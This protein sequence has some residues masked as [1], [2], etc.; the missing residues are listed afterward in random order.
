[1]HPSQTRARHARAR[2]MG[3]RTLGPARSRGGDWATA[4]TR[5]GQDRSQHS[6]ETLPAHDTQEGLG[7]E[8]R[9]LPLTKDRPLPRPRL[10]SGSL[11][12]APPCFSPRPPGPAPPLSPVR[13]PSRQPAHAPP[14]P[15]HGQLHHQDKV[16]RRRQLHPVGEPQMV[17]Q[18]LHLLGLSVV[19][20]QAAG[21]NAEGHR[22]HLGALLGWNPGPG[23]VQ[24]H[25]AST[26]V[27][28][29]PSSSQTS[30]RLALEGHPGTPL[31]TSLRSVLSL[32]WALAHTRV[33]HHGSSLTGVEVPRQVPDHPPHPQMAWLFLASFLQRE[34]RTSRCPVVSTTYFQ[35]TLKSPLNS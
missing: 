18:N 35:E 8:R 29:P 14:D 19:L 16:L 3:L 31:Q 9:Q 28:G 22:G 25:L 11:T 32:T 10:C 33:G 26:G 21:A 13:R 4:G 17:Q 15:H 27:A 24:A 5:P 34:V 20:Q 23:P 30:S 7:K 1:M 2:C 12:Q 6:A